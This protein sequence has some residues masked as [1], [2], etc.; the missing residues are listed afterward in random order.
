[1][2]D[3]GQ[4]NVGR[5]DANVDGGFIFYQYCGGKGGGGCLDP[6]GVTGIVLSYRMPRFIVRNKR[7]IFENK[8]LFGVRIFSDG[9][10]TGFCDHSTGVEQGF[11]MAL[12]ADGNLTDEEVQSRGKFITGALPYDIE[13]LAK[14][15]P[16]PVQASWDGYIFVHLYWGNTSFVNEGGDI[17]ENSMRIKKHDY[18]IQL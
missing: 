7:I 4:A 18:D 6:L 10:A 3:T 17:D 12:S 15:I 5:P 9:G 16:Q 2:S 11:Y 1:M 13:F 8:E 14:D